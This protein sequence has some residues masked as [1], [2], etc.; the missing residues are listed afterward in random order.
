MSSD[1]AA[2]GARKSVHALEHVKAWLLG[3][4]AAL[5]GLPVLAALTPGALRSPELLF[6]LILAAAL[7][8][9]VLLVASRVLLVRH[10]RVELY[11]NGVVVDRGGVRQ[12]ALFDEVT[13]LWMP[14]TFAGTTPLTVAVLRELRLVE[15]SGRTTRVPLLGRD[16]G[17]L[18][19]WVLRRCLDRPR[20]AAREAL[21]RGE[22]VHFGRVAL[23]SR[24]VRVGR[25]ACDWEQ[26]RLVLLQPGSVSLFRRQTVFPWKVVELDTVPNAPVFHQLVTEL[27]PKTE[28]DDPL[29]K[30]LRG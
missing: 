19:N 4:A 5:V 27:A 13:E 24:G 6:P 16:V 17:A 3:G 11:W 12:V 22:E 30:L 7:A 9:G 23:S 2:L 1:E 29:G 10:T 15:A 20:R 25:A 14:L 18:G 8:A 28:V 26:V 21:A